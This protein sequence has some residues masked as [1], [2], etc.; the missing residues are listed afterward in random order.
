[1]KMSLFIAMPSINLN[2]LLPPT[3]Q[4]LYLSALRGSPR[5]AHANLKLTQLKITNSIERNEVEV[6]VVN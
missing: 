3:S 4:V 6:K 5:L 1:M 2:R